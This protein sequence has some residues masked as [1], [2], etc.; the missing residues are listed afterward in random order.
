MAD[1]KNSPK[2]HVTEKILQVLQQNL[3]FTV[4]QTQLIAIFE[5]KL[6][7]PELSSGQISSL[8]YVEDGRLGTA[9]I[10]DITFTSLWTSE[11]DDPKVVVVSNLA[12]FQA[13]LEEAANFG[14]TVA[15]T[16]NL[17]SHIIQSLSL[18]P[19]QSLQNKSFGS[20]PNCIPGFNCPPND[21]F[22]K[23]R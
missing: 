20:G 14:H 21:P 3:G 6:A 13:K 16:I 22:Y 19:S 12:T 8:T 18:Y 2:F 23:K 4:D 11:K 7:V 1:A 10:D 15:L 17:E 5:G 9:T